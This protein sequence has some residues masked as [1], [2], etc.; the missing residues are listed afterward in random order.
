MG[1]PGAENIIAA[2][3]FYLQCKIGGNSAES[4]NVAVSLRNFSTFGSSL[5]SRETLGGEG[6]IIA[7][8]LQKCDTNPPQI[9]LT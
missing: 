2:G 6:G 8:T 1:W 7:C 3:G 5:D 4:S 9:A